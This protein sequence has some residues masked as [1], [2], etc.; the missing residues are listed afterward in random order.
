MATIAT[1][2]KAFEADN[3]LR[4]MPLT[5]VEGLPA[6]KADAVEGGDQSYAW[7]MPGD[8]D[9]TESGGRRRCTVYQNKIKAARLDN[10]WLESLKG[11]AAVPFGSEPT[12]TGW[13]ASIQPTEKDPGFM[14]SVDDQGRSLHA[15]W[16]EVFFLKL[17]AGIHYLVIDMP[18][19]A[20]GSAYWT[21]FAAGNVLDVKTT[22]VDGRQRPVEVRLSWQRSIPKKPGTD[23]EDWP[24]SE[25]EEVVRIY[26]VSEIVP[27][28]G[29]IG[30]LGAGVEGGPVFF[31][32]SALRK[33]GDA[34][35]WT[36]ISPWRHLEAK[37]GVMTEIPLVP[38]Y[39]NRVAAYRGRPAFLATAS[40][41]MALW[42]KMLDYDSRERRDAINLMVVKGANESET[43]WDGHTMWIPAAAEVE[44]KETT[45]AALEALRASHE[46]LRAQIKTGNLR[47][48]QAA[49]TVTKT[50]TEIS[51]S[52]LTA[53]SLLE[54]L[55]LLDIAS[56]TQALK[57]TA[58]LNGEDGTGGAVDLPHDFGLSPGAMA[59]LFGGYIESGGVLVPPSLV[60]PE[61]KR[62]QMVGE[63][64][65]V[66]K[67]VAQ[68][69]ASIDNRLAPAEPDPEPEKPTTTTP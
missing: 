32:E 27:A 2:S 22:M 21:S 30:A 68:T 3:K 65:D 38:F 39:G 25:T 59:E 12:L 33:V 62:H 26:R 53:D 7:P 17:A 43:R 29:E 20:G 18:P 64:V 45:G 60:W 15:F 16:S 57:Y 56:M 19:E 5:L 35:R 37:R 1:R 63:R 8:Q 6:L 52:K 50:A 69:Q 24:E 51:V 11:C 36:W 61:A 9:I 13:P 40:L 23:P 58:T 55:V 67:L 10:A 34:L 49:P 66:D 28:D 42:R 48:V 54:M 4:H 14:A 44:L 47:P 41:Q 46:D 31:R